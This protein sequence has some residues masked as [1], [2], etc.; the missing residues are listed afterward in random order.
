MTGIYPNMFRARRYDDGIF[1]IDHSMN[2]YPYNI[3]KC[4]KTS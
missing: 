1:N 3:C 2:L 4:I